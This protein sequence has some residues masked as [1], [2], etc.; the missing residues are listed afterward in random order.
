MLDR[1][2]V[3]ATEG[4]EDLEDQEGLDCGNGVLKE[5][6]FLKM[7]GNHPACLTTDAPVPLLASC[8]GDCVWS[9]NRF[10]GRTLT[11]LLR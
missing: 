8:F 6:Y 2:D 10:G 9:A 4:E 1:R 11:G 3:L 5:V 7:V